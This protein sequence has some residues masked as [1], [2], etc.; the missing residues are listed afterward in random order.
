LYVLVTC[1]F[2]LHSSI[3]ES[4]YVGICLLVVVHVK[5]WAQSNF[6]SHDIQCQSC[7]LAIFKT[8]A[9]PLMILVSHCQAKYGLWISGYVSISRSLSQFSSPFSGWW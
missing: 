2:A 5:I 7:D 1:L 6:G 4:C 9:S 3:A 8:Q